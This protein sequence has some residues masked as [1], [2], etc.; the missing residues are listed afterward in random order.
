VLANKVV[1]GGAGLPLGL[2]VIVMYVCDKA[3]P[4]GLAYGLW[5]TIYG[6]WFTAYGL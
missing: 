6:V 3:A 4:F 2:G 5:L 1:L